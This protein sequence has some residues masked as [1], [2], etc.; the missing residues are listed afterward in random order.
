MNWQGRRWPWID[1]KS[2]VTASVTAIRSGLTSM[3]QVIRDAGGDPE[4]VR[5]EIADD[6]KQMRAAGID[7]ALISVIV[8]LLPAPEASPNKADESVAKEPAK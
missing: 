3:S 7:E 2:D 1:P 4:Q 6:L 8:G 5:A